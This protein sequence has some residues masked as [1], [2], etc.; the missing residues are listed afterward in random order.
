[1]P[2]G[3]AQPADCRFS[4][5]RPGPGHGN[6]FQG[7]RQPM[8][9]SE[10][11]LS[12]GTLIRIGAGLSLDIQQRLKRPGAPARVVLVEPHPATAKALGARFAT[13]PEVS[14]LPVAVGGADALGDAALHVLSD[15]AHS[16]LHR[17]LPLLGALLPGLRPAGST[18]VEVIS[19]AELFDRLGT[20]PEPIHVELDAP[21]SE[22]VILAGLQHAGILDR[23][24]SVD[25][26]CGSEPLYEGAVPASALATWLTEAG[27]QR[28]ESNADDPDWPEMRVAADL[29]QRAT[30]ARNNVLVTEVAASETHVA[31]LEAALRDRDT[32]LAEVEA[33]LADARKAAAVQSQRL[34]ELEKARTSQSQDQ[35]S[36]T[37]ALAEARALAKAQTDLANQRSASLAKVEAGL[38]AANEALTEKSKALVAAQEATKAAVAAQA[39]ALQTAEAKAAESAAAAAVQAARLAEAERALADQRRLTEA[40]QGDLAAARAATAKAEGEARAAEARLARMQDT[41]S[42]LQDQNGALDDAVQ[43]AAFDSQS[44]RQDLGLSLRL[45][46][47]LQTDLRDLQGRFEEVMAVRREQDDLLRQLTPRLR[48]A[49]QQLQALALVDRD[50]A[51]RGGDPSA[52]VAPALPGKAPKR[53]KKP[54]L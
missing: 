25:L 27:F 20:L 3:Q 38:A 15:P 19:A 42:A 34:A 39:Q 45:Q 48:E 37:A 44:A 31:E 18:T 51:E 41:L 29:P 22:A 32:R 21:G 35:D 10:R 23:I 6:R 36:R 4:V 2:L 11:D 49:A 43:R 7:D 54:K 8:V 40:L 12:Q 52:N 33:Q 9:L 1:M 16:S 24:A 46:S 53:P 17:P 47:R 13:L 28:L 14:V 50:A 26:R 30:Q 5:A